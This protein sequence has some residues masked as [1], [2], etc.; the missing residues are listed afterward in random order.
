M[1]KSE[2]KKYFIKGIPSDKELE[3][4]GDLMIEDNAAKKQEK[5][6][7]VSRKRPAKKKRQ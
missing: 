4:L 6:K 5:K 3:D 7:P 1:N 2:N